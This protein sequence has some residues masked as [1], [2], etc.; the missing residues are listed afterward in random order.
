M[1][2]RFR[3]LALAVLALGVLGG[4]CGGSIKA[5]AISDLVEKVTLRHDALLD[6]TPDVNGDGK[7]DATD[8]ADKATYKRSSK[9][10]TD[11]VKEAE[12]K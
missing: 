1:Q 3:F 2:T 6:R 8:E 10:L 5:S 9:L 12:K 4:C 11:V 7:G